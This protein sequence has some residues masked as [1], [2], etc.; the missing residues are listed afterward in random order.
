[1][2]IMDRLDPELRVV[3][4][5]IPALDLTDIPAAR[6]S[7]A[8]LYAQINTGGPNPRVSHSDHMAPGREGNPDV[9]VRVFRPVAAASSPLPCLYW[10][11]G[12]GYVLTA[13]DMDDQFCQE[14]VDRHECV[15]VSVDW[16]RAP[17][18]PFPAPA[19]DCYAGLAW[20]VS[21]ADEL[22]I[23]PGRIVI[24]GHSS[25]GG[26]TAGLA[27]LVRDRGEFTVAHQL[28]VYPMLDDTN[29]TPFSHL[30][31]DPQVWN[32]TSNEIGWRGY[33]GDTY[34]TEDVSPY[35]APTRMEDLAGLP[36]A[37]VLTGELDLFVDE[38]V[39][40]AQRLM[41]AGVPTELHVYRA[42]H[43]GFDRMVPQA[44]VSQR[45]IADRDA[46][47]QFGFASRHGTTS[48]PLPVT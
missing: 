5:Q 45:F 1:V 6:A 36:P 20:T 38:D 24:G 2:P 17:E 28:L 30:V 22:G 23:D 43:H 32:R 47:L 3:V 31:T 42:A 8:E 19:E 26:S 39:D 44:K 37:T 34:G 29:S 9:M 14:I 25:G 27:L 16:R 11:Q 21:N 48:V 41:R 12:G 10:T 13:P 40:Y 15:V 7:L 18:H 46:A 33:L 4:E 35:A